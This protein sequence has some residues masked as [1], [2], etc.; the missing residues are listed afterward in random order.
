M[1]ESPREWWLVPTLGGQCHIADPDRNKVS[2]NWEYH[3]IEYSAYEAVRKER[4]ELERHIGE[5][6][7]DIVRV[8]KERDEL[9][10]TKIPDIPREP[11]VALADYD[12]LAQER[13]ALRSQLEVATEALQKLITKWNMSGAQKTISYNIA[14]Q[15]L[16]QIRKGAGE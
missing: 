7:C 8:T 12:K 11:F 4:D 10:R 2:P 9:L 6:G 1:S 14:F 5:H 13:D 15:A 3:V 16:E